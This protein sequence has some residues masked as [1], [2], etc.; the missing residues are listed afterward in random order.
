[1][2]AV[3]EPRMRIELPARALTLDDVTE[4]AAADDVHRYE[5]DEGI[6]LIVAPADG[7]HADFIMRIGAW[8]IA[9]G[10]GPGCVLATPG[11]RIAGRTAGRSPD[12]LVLRQPAPAVV[13]HDA[14]NTV[15]AVEIVSPGSETLD[16]VVKPAEYAR[17]GVPHFWRVERDRGHA[18]AHMY[19][20][21]VDERG[22]PVYLGHR[23]KLLEDLLVS[24]PPRL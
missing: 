7:E 15:L 20:L 14:A 17:A 22:E 23:A 6:L 11:L 16:R 21:G 9:N 4:L 18:T 2:T 10:Y 24:E 3:D 19:T 12:I 5:L 13:W 8:L 1:M